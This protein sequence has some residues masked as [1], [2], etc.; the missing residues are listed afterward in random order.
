MDERGREFLERRA[1]GARA[2]RATREAGAASRAAGVGEPP[3]KPRS[4]SPATPDPRRGESRAFRGYHPAG[5]HSLLP[6]AGEE[7]E[8]GAARVRCRFAGNRSLLPLACKWGEAGASRCERRDAEERS[9]TRA[10][11]VAGLGRR[12]FA[13]AAPR[14]AGRLTSA[15][16]AERAHRSGR[17]KAPTLLPRAARSA[18]SPAST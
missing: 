7:R 10:R 6:F 16:G 5:D 2:L 9:L 4:R 8:G 18:L 11:R 12:G 3:A 15:P 1:P 14:N 13:L 17:V